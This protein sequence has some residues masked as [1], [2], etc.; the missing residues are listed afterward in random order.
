M[1][2]GEGGKIV[3]GRFKLYKSLPPQGPLP[4]TFCTSKGRCQAISAAS[5]DFKNPD[6]PRKVRKDALQRRSV[7]PTLA[8]SGP[9]GGLVCKVPND[10]NVQQTCSH[11]V[12][13]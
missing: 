10:P 12:E 2:R 8:E 1:G 5:R 4:C 6:L 11:Y 3:R 13:N 7:P 9:R